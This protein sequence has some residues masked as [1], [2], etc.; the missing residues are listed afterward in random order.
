M[1]GAMTLDPTKLKAVVFDY[2]NTLIEFTR[3]HVT[4]LDEAIGRT[5]HEHFGPYDEE[6]YRTLRNSAYREP[7][8]HPEL[9]EPPLGELLSRLV[10]ELHGVEPTAEQLAALERMGERS[11]DNLLRA[12][13]R[14][15]KTALGRFI[16][17]LGIREVGEVTAASLAQHFGSLENLRRADREQLLAVADVGPVVA[18][19]VLTF[20]SSEASTA[21]VRRLLEAGV[22]WPREASRAGEA[23]PLEDRTWVVTGRLEALSREQ[24]TATGSRTTNTMRKSRNS[25]QKR[26]TSAADQ[27]SGVQTLLPTT[28]A[29]SRA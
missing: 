12:L 2:G 23:R 28:G 26:M 14:S 9:R 27:T 3:P 16:Y 17:A 6:R 4:Q 25:R 1:I 21:V 24:A 13:E 10:R 22:D 15:K 18:D 8:F 7:Y 29:S 11:A 5:I 20:F 19:H